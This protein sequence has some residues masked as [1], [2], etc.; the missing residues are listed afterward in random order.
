MSTLPTIVEKTK[1]MEQWNNDKKYCMSG[2]EII[3]DLVSSG[4][5]SKLQNGN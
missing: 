3:F 2:S 5:V 4:H 1:S